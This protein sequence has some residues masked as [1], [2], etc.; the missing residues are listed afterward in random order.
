[1]SDIV[2]REQV[3]QQGV[4]AAG[5]VVGGAAL[6][7]LTALPPVA[8]AVAGGA[9]VLLG[10]SQTRSRQDRRPGWVVA[11][12]GAATLA[13]GLIPGL[14]GLAGA[15]LTLSGVGLLGVGGYNLFQFI[16]NLRRRM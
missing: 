5:G 15:L 12:V 8:A 1:M 4:R 13:A 10:L 3:S 2:P 11:A 6:L 14:G 9:L 16:R 7:V